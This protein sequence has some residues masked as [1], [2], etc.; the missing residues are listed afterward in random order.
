MMRRS[1]NPQVAVDGLIDAYLADVEIDF[2]DVDPRERAAVLAGLREHID[3]ALRG[4]ARAPSP[5]DVERVLA[6]LGPVASLRAAVEPSAPAGPAR[7]TPVAI[8]TLL[9]AVLSVPLVVVNAAVAA[10]VGLLAVTIALVALRGADAASRGL[11]KL[12]AGIGGMGLLLALLY[13]LT[14]LGS[15]AG[16]VDVEPPTQVPEPTAGP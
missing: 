2:A 13:A 1:S 14:L 9:L 8:A 7:P 15:S 11:F 3:D 6:E 10:V 5:A 12:A 4:L 16:P